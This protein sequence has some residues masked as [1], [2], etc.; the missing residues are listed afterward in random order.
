MRRDWILA[1]IV[2]VMTLFIFLTVLFAAED[3][4]EKI[5]QTKAEIGELSIQEKQVDAQIQ[6]LQQRKEQILQVY[7]QQVNKLGELIR[8]QEQVIKAQEKVQKE[9]E[10]TPNQTETRLDAPKENE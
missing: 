4:S 10:I 3:I 5:L 2:F 7:F 6:A 9:T 1:G 8:K